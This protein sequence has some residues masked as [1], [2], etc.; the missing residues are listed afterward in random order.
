MV[1]ICGCNFCYKHPTAPK[2]TQLCT[3]RNMQQIAS[4]LFLPKVGLN[5]CACGQPNICSIVL[6]LYKFQFQTSSVAY[7]SYYKANLYTFYNKLRNNA[8]TNCLKKFVYRSH[9]KSQQ[10]RNVI[11]NHPSQQ[12]KKVTSL[13]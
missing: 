6:T 10:E 1:G 9:S 5:G 3:L 13:K 4:H 11:L 2:H 12:S 7:K 8:G